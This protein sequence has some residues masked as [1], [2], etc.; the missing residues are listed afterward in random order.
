MPPTKR[1]SIE[2][3]G[4]KLTLDEVELCMP[5]SALSP[6]AACPCTLT[7]GCEKEAGHKK[8]CVARAVGRMN[9]A[10]MRNRFPDFKVE[11]HYEEGY[12][13]WLF[14]SPKGVSKFESVREVEDYLAAVKEAVA[15]PDRNEADAAGGAEKKAKK[16][17]GFKRVV[18]KASSR[19][20][21]CFN[22]LFLS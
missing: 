22:E 16:T 7:E 5:A 21:A 1:L 18:G 17:R 12:V 13:R 14:T 3:D 9:R 10:A 2:T 20:F 15:T 11:Q 6:K 4:A 8:R 19:V